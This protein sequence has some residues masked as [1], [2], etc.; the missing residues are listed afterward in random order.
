MR[1][2]LDNAILGNYTRHMHA[3]ADRELSSPQ[4]LEITVRNT[5]N[6]RKFTIIRLNK[7][8][9]ETARIDSA[10]GGRVI[11]GPLKLETINA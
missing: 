5:E 1:S 3:D 11:L 4:Q 7:N 9:K 6:R 8:D 2:R 10:V